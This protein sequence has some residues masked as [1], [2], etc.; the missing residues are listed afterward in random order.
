MVNLILASINTVYVY[1]DDI[2]FVTKGTKQEHVNKVR[3]VMRVLG[4]ANLQLKAR[5][6]IIA[7]ESIEWPCSKL[8]RTSISPGNTKSQDISER[9]R[10]THLKQIR[11][12][13]RTVNQFNKFI[14]SLV[15]INFP[16]ISVLKKVADS[17]WNDSHEKAFKK[18]NDEI[19]IDV[20]LSQFKKT[21]EIRIICDASKQ[22]PGAVLQ[23]RQKDGECS[24]I[25]VASRFL[26]KVETKDSN[27]ELE[28]LAILWAVEHFK[29]YVYVVQVK[30][31]LDHKALM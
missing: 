20:E 13:L 18:I 27:N 21:Q 11:S 23:Q 5:K 24:P 1:T 10:P 6:C 17:E 8:T 4:D 9:L 30:V 15:S 31:F 28:L 29:N 22:G 2:L 7:Q 14:L 16:F 26:I 19:K 3:E 25:C 12:F